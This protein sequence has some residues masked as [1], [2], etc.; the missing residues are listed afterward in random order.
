[1][2]Q[3]DQRNISILHRVDEERGKEWNELK[4][5]CRKRVKS[6]NKENEKENY[7]APFG[8]YSAY[9]TGMKKWLRV[10]LLKLLFVGFLGNGTKCVKP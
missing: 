7:G 4:L 9:S 5:I 8:I 10:D 3:T 6:R 1:M 2:G